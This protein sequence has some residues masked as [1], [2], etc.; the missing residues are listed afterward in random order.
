MHRQTI[1]EA[2]KRGSIPDE[3]L[4]TNLGLFQSR[5]SLSRLLLM[6]SL[7]Q[8][9]INVP[10]SIIEFGTRWGQNLALFANFRGMYEPYNYSRLLIGFDTFSGLPKIGDK[11]G[12]FL[13]EGGFSVSPG[14]EGELAHILEAHEAEYPYADRRKFTLIK[15]DAINTFPDYLKQNPHTVIALAYFD[16]DLYA[17]TKVCLELTLERVTKGSVVVFD[18][19]N[20]GE[21]P[22]ETLA[23][24]EVLGLSREELRRDPFNPLTAYYVVS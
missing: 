10:G 3:E 2:L 9:I 21:F 12:T 17:P 15:G 4:L 19:L 11:D 13:K 6:H 14:Y 1:F 5:R 24:M 23:V 8:K 16:F 7:Y 20:W 22:G 18:E